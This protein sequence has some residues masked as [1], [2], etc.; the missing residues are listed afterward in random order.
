M[1]LKESEQ[2][3]PLR[4][5]SSPSAR[6][7]GGDARAPHGIADHALERSACINGLGPHDAIK[8]GQ[9]VKI[10]VSDSVMAKRSRNV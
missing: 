1:S 2:V 6:R 5:K 7:Y 10:V 3:Q 9:K 8:P 4:L